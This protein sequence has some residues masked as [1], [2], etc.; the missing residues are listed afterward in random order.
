LSISDET[1]PG[2][3]TPDPVRR[4]AALTATLVA[5]PLTLLIAVISLWIFGGFAVFS[6]PA[7]AASPSAKPQASTLVVLP[8]PS[9]SEDVAVVCRQVIAALPDTVLGGK[10]RPVDG[11]EQNAAYGDPPVTVA[12]GVAAPTVGVTED[13]AQLS[14]VCW[15]ADTG[16][17]SI[18]F[19][20][21]DRSVPISV[22]VPGGPNG[23]AQSVIGFSAAIKAQ[24]PI[25]AHYPPG[26]D[27]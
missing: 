16:A 5:G 10:R 4:S 9:L 6:S 22:T 7:P 24:D 11:P 3:R 27:G 19:F 2:P 13:V 23:S 15:I 8:T 14:G 21:V 18:T 20:T 12:C 26:C 17:A 1:G 25:A